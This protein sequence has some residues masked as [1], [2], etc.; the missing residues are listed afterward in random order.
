MTH[1]SLWY[2]SRKINVSHI[3]CQKI[4]FYFNVCPRSSSHSPLSP[5]TAS[6]LLFYFN[7]SFVLFFF[8]IYFNVFLWSS[9]APLSFP[10]FPHHCFRPAYL[11]LRA[12]KD[13][14]CGTKWRILEESTKL[15]I[16]HRRPIFSLPHYYFDGSNFFDENE[17]PDACGWTIK[18]TLWNISCPGWLF[19][20]AANP[21]HGTSFGCSLKTVH[22]Q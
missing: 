1:K 4:L 19:D 16:E 9:S 15:T 21:V 10:P 2:S 22:A 7:F 20:A 13:S 8:I 17:N 3:W 5:T 14:I 11:Q 18:C 12:T 6:V